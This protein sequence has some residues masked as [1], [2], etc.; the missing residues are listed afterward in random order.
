M[1]SR[2]KRRILVTST[3]AYEILPPFGRLN[4]KNEKI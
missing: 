1:S 4:D 3:Y 2:A